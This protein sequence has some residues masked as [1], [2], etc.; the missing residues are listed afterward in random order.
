MM[1][2]TV[3]AC[4][5]IKKTTKPCNDETLSV[6]SFLTENICSWLLS[7][8]PP[9]FVWSPSLVPHTPGRGKPGAS[10]REDSQDGAED[11][12]TGV[13]RHIGAD[14]DLSRVAWADFF[15]AAGRWWKGHVH[16]RRAFVDRWLVP[17]V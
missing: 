11:R 3:N 12:A 10:S 7:F 14:G 17:M 6:R 9:I 15:T 1:E 2:F 16:Q 5:T 13:Y 4:K 8:S